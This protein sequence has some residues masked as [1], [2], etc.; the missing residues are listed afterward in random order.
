MAGGSIAQK[1]TPLFK[2]FFN[3][4]DIKLHHLSQGSLDVS[5]ILT[6]DA[7]DD[8]TTCFLKKEGSL[9]PEEGAIQSQ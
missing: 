1:S 3:G 7:D 4:S 8:E 6:D 2:P 9:E 5:I